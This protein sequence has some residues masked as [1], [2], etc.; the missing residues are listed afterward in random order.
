MGDK[1]GS[2]CITCQHFD[3]ARRRCNACRVGDVDVGN[4]STCGKFEEKDPDQSVKA[5]A[6]KLQ[7]TLVP[8][9]IVRCIAAV[10]MYGVEKYGDPDNWKRVEIERY[11]DAL[12]R[13][14][15]AYLEDPQGADEESGMPHLWH[16]ACN[17]AFLCALEKG[18]KP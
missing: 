8:W 6:G 16:A 2:I 12:C 15:L 7:L 17:L 5:D 9:E 18:R 3:L 13:H 11:R 4:V 14:W 1:K 10:R